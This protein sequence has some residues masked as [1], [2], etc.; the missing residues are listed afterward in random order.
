MLPS[1][2]TLLKNIHSL[3]YYIFKQMSMR[4]VIIK[5]DKPMQIKRKV[6]P[7]KALYGVTLKTV[8]YIRRKP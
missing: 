4:Y 8:M 5:S 1:T 3:L 6:T 2:L 7:H